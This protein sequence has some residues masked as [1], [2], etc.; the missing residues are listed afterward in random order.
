MPA[1]TKGAVRC[2]PCASGARN[3]TFG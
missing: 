1:I 2:A 3:A